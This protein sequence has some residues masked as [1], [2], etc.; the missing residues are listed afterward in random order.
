MEE[1]NQAFNTLKLSV[2]ANNMA[3]AFK[4]EKCTEVSI[5]INPY[6]C[7]KGHI[8]CQKCIDKCVENKE[9]C[10]NGNHE[11]TA[12]NQN[13]GIKNIISS[14]QIVCP[15]N[16]KYQDKKENDI[17]NQ[18]EKC[19]WKGNVSA[20]FDHLP[21]CCVYIAFNKV[22]KSDIKLNQFKQIINQNTKDTNSL[23]QTINKMA[24]QI[25]DLAETIKTTQQELRHLKQTLQNKTGNSAI[26][27]QDDVKMDIPLL[28]ESNIGICSKCNKQII[29]SNNNMKLVNNKWQHVNC[30]Y[31]SIILTSSDNDIW[32]D[33]F[34]GAFLHIDKTVVTL[35][36]KSNTS[37]YQSVFGLIT[38]DNGIKQWKIRI[39]KLASNDI[40]IGVIDALKLPQSVSNNVY[41]NGI[42]LHANG[43]IYRFD[44][45]SYPC[46]HQFKQGDIISIILDIQ[47]RILIFK[48]ND[49]TIM[50][51]VNDLNIDLRNYK[52]K[53]FA[54][55]YNPGD[56]IILL[57]SNKEY[58][59]G[60]TF[61]DE[62]LDINYQCKQ[63]NASISKRDFEINNI[64]WS[65][66]DKWQ[67]NDCNLTKY[68]LPD[69]SDPN[70]PDE[71]NKLLAFK[72][73]LILSNNGR[74]FISAKSS[75]YQTVFGVMSVKA[76]QKSWSIKIDNLSSYM[77]IGIIE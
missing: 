49:Y 16:D 42:S 40:Y 60:D 61:D 38:L 14:L 35:D 27:N 2:F 68:K 43:H 10:P 1:F 11:I 25:T 48:I 12:S 50:V 4:C 32:Y 45:D 55:L 39:N 30:D 59:P 31:K 28:Q 64:H 21:K 69:L 65:T 26:D 52:W 13:V 75:V 46:G 24:L 72:A 3:A 7:D 71:F 44:K 15:M 18:S 17:S 22:F 36:P 58:E 34:R 56:Q 76:Q 8:F 51:S 70:K 73:D 29:Y 19:E 67:H 63:C 5:P 54:S 9:E 6:S 62:K 77:Y 66:E 41:K 74:T 47:N 33:A 23:K 37:F 20:L 57:N 53:L